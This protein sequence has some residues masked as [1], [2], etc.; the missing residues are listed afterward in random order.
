MGMGCNC[1]QFVCYL[2]NNHRRNVYSDLNEQFV[3]FSLIQTYM[4]ANFRTNVPIK[5]NVTWYHGHCDKLRGNHCKLQHFPNF[6]CT[7]NSMKRKKNGCGIHCVDC[8][9]ST[10]T[11][12][13]SE[14]ATNSYAVAFFLYKFTHCIF[15]VCTS[16][17]QYTD[18]KNDFFH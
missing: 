18:E 13:I 4:N 11:F 17:T 16:A 2:S 15:H 8:S 10:E 1:A 5:I 7:F 14:N 3:Q 6:D 9:N 12:S